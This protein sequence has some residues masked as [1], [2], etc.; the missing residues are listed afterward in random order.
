MSSTITPMGIRDDIT[1]CIG[2]TPLVRLQ[3]ATEDCKASVIAKIENMVHQLKTYY[4][5][6]VMDTYF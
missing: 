2:R 6:D 4:G 3:R 1:Q 5:A